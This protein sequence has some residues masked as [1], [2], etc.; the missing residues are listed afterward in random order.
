MITTINEFKNSINENNQY[1]LLDEILAEIQPK[2]DDMLERIKKWH[3][4]EY[5]P[6]MSKFSE[7]LEKLNLKFDLMK[8]IEKYTK[9][10]DILVDISTT[11]SRKRNLEINATIKRDEIDYPFTT[12]VIYAGGHTTQRLH[13]RYITKTKLP[14]TGNSIITQKLNTKIKRLTKIEKIQEEINRTIKQI[15]SYKKKVEEINNTTDDEILLNNETYQMYKNLTWQELIN[16]GNDKNY[17]YDENNFINAREEMK[18]KAIEGFRN[19]VSSYSLS[20]TSLK[21][22]V[23]KQYKKIEDL[24]QDDNND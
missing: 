9:P 1:R 22:S 15:E 7:D 12:E 20:I 21:K 14:Q 5:K 6:P 17:D 23:E 16:R 18:Q 11:V 8:A 4:E 10:T 24:K 13:Y 19:N 2:L 3:L